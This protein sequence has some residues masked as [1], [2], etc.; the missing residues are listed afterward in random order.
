MAVSNRIPRFKKL[1]GA[2]DAHILINKCLWLFK[3]ERKKSR[4]SFSLCVLFF[5]MAIKLLGH[6]HTKLPS[7]MDLT[8]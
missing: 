8:N 5:Q 4:V 1:C 3:D 2:Q 7:C 6:T